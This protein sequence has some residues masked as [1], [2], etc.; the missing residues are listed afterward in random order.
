M[1]PLMRSWRKWVALRSSGWLIRKYDSVSSDFVKGYCRRGGAEGGGGGM[2]AAREGKRE[3]SALCDGC[4][5]R[6]K[7]WLNHRAGLERPPSL[8]AGLTTGRSFEGHLP[9]R[10]AS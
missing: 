6:E 1:W 3:R 10:Q 5:S 4:Y 9:R 8:F 2:E 7:G